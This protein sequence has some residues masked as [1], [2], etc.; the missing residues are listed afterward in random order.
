MADNVTAESDAAIARALRAAA[1]QA[2]YQVSTL[3][4]LRIGNN[5]IY[6]DRQNHLIYRVPVLRREAEDLVA[7]NDRLLA[8]DV[9]GAPILPPL[10]RST[11]ALSTGDLATVWPLGGEAEANPATALAPA[12][13][14][15]HQVEPVDGLVIWEGFERGHRRVELARTTGVPNDLV[16]EISGRLTTLESGIPPWST[17]TVVHGD[18]HTGNLV[19]AD[20]KHLLIDLD[21]LA[22]G[23]PEID[24]APMRTGYTRF[25]QLTGSWD[26]FVAAYGRPYD[27]DMLDWF[28][29]VRQV[30]M[31]AW[32]FTLWDLRPESQAEAVHRVS[33]LDTAAVWNPL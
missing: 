13:A 33:T 1:S 14:S 29:K 15:L 2:G 31:I 4:L 32:L 7:E 23:C 24:L 25:T 19:K 3:E 8:L 21:D 17:E 30:S 26:E 11:L 10:Q 27:A 18:P 20:G 5:R 28:V 6:A 12:L 9:A 22:R 16:D